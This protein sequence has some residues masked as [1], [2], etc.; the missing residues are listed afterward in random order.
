M[1]VKEGDDAG[2]NDAWGVNSH[3]LEGI[4]QYIHSSPFTPN[5]NTLHVSNGD[6]VERGGF[7]MS[8]Q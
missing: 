5:A 1:N 2:M 8:K 6:N 3:T 7:V 4:M